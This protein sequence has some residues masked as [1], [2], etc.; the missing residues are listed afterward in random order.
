MSRHCR[1]VHST[2]PLPTRR[3]PLRRRTEGPKVGELRA[4]AL[5]LMRHSNQQRSEQ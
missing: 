2:R 3:Q 4:L 5:M 1:M